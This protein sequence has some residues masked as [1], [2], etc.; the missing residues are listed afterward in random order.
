MAIRCLSFS[1]ISTVVLVHPQP[2][3]FVLV[4]GSVTG[5]VT[6]PVDVS[7]IEFRN[8]RVRVLM[9]PLWEMLLFLLPRNESPVAVREFCSL[10]FFDWCV[11]AFETWVKSL[12]TAAT[13]VH[14]GMVLLHHPSTHLETLFFG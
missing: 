3:D 12:L 6:S 13:S 2:P 4:V 8:S 1:S 9:L 11:S 7:V 10:S 5:E 14:R